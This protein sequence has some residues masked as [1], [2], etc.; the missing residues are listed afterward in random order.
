MTKSSK[1]YWGIGISIGVIGIG[2]LIYVNRKHINPALNQADQTITK[3][4]RQVTEA[5]KKTVKKA[6]EAGKQVLTTLGLWQKP[7][8]AKRISSPFGNRV[9]P[10][11]KKQQ[12]HNGIDLPVPVGT[13]VKSPS[14]GVVLNSFNND[15]GGNQVTIKH[16]NGYQT[17]Y[18]HLSKSLVKKGD[19]VKKGQVI[20]LSGNTGRSTGPHLHLTLR[21]SEGKLVDPAK[22]IY[23]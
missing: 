5:G 11:T 15:L 20:A 18:A 12:Y 22:V 19:K 2:T 23:T 10:V 16:N 4:G 13:D 21:D 6:G 8:A 14:D 1:I 9:N 7:V 3:A 17:G